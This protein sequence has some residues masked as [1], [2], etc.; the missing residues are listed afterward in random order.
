MI[1]ALSS[2]SPAHAALP[3]R[4]AVKKFVYENQGLVRRMYGDMRHIFVMQSELDNE[5]DFDDIHDSA[6]KYSKVFND[7]NKREMKARK[8]S[9]TAER[10]NFRSDTEPYFRPAQRPSAVNTK[11]KTKPPKVASNEPADSS[12]LD[13]LIKSNIDAIAEDL[14]ENATK[15]TKLTSVPASSTTP[16]TVS[17]TLPDLAV[18]LSNETSSSV[19]VEV[20]SLFSNISSALSS[21]TPSSGTTIA[22]TTT[23]GANDTVD[24]LSTKLKN[25]LASPNSLEKVELLLEEEIVKDLEEVASSATE[26]FVDSED[27]N[28]SKEPQTTTTETQLFQDTMKEKEPAPVVNRRGV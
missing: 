23:E 12:I 16:S 1:Y 2:N 14:R 11:Q 26:T 15:T 7:H 27:K 5:I 25:E 19:R 24:K 18:A 4:N 13:N 6:D 8:V 3:R 22:S 21:T 10:K 17:S 20:L 9:A 28:N